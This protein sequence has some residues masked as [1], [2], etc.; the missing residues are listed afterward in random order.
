LPKDT[1]SKL[2][3]L[4]SVFTL[5]LFNAERQAGKLWIPTFKSLLAWLN[6]GI[7]RWTTKRML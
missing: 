1:T 4:S 6:D 3:G 7:R 5:S 2:A